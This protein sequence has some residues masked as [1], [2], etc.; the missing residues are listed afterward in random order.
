MFNICYN[1]V[2][3]KEVIILTFGLCDLKVSTPCLV[4]DVPLTSRCSRF[5]AFKAKWTRLEFVTCG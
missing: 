4:T 5:D 2:S 1:Y 3:S